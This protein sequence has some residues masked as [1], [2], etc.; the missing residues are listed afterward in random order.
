MSGG[1][2]TWT[3]PD[4]MKRNTNVSCRRLA[5]AVVRPLTSDTKLVKKHGDLH[6]F[7]VYLAY[8]AREVRVGPLVL[9]AESELDM[10]KWMLAFR[11]AS[12]W[13]YHPPCLY[14]LP[15]RLCGL[16]V[17]EIISVEN[18]LV[19][20]WGGKSD[21]YVMVEFDGLLARTETHYDSLTSEF[22]TVVTLP[23][24]NDDPN[25][26]LNFSIFDE[27]SLSHDDLL[28]GVSVPLHSLGFNQ[29]I[30]WDS[31]SVKNVPGSIA[32]KSI[33]SD[34]FGSISFRTLYRSSHLTQFLPLNQI[35]SLVD[36]T[37]GSAPDRIIP[38]S[39]SR[40]GSTLVRRGTSTFAGNSFGRRQSMAVLDSEES[41]E[42]EK[43]P[44]KKTTVVEKKPALSPA[45]PDSSPPATPTG[46]RPVGLPEEDGSYEFSIE[47]F[48]KQL[49]RIVAILKVLKFFKSAS[50]LIAWRDPSWTILI[51]VWVSW[52][53]LVEPQSALMFWY[54]M[55]GKMLLQGH[56]CF[57]DLE[58]E[59]KDWWG[60]M[61]LDRLSLKRGTP[62]SSVGSPLNRN[63]GTSGS[64]DALHEY[65]V[66][67]CQ[68]RR[69]AGAMTMLTTMV[70]VTATM[71]A[72]MAVAAGNAVA[73]PLMT[74]EDGLEHSTATEAV[75]EAKK[76][77]E[78]LFINFSNKNLKPD[79]EASW[80]TLAGVPLAESPATVI[81]GVKVK[82]NVVISKKISDKNG[83]EYAKAFPA[84]AAGTTNPT[85]KFDQHNSVW[86]AGGFEPKLK[87]HRHW[88]RRR[89]WIGIPIRAAF[90][91]EEPIKLSQIVES[92]VDKDGEELVEEGKKH[93]S[94]Y[95]KF[96][97]IMVE[98]RKLQ[99]VL[100]TVVSGLECAKN[101]VTWKSRWISSLVFWMIMAVLLFSLVIPQ[102]VL[103]WLFFSLMLLDSFSDV[104]KKANLT[105]PLLEA[106][107]KE[108]AASSVPAQ[109]KAILASKLRSHYTRMD[110]VHSEVSVSIICSL[111]QK[112]C[113]KVWFPNAV[114]L[115]LED[116]AVTEVSEG[117]PATVAML[118]ERIYL[119]A[120]HGDSDWWKSEK[121][122]IHPK[123][124][125]KGHLVSD[126]EEYDPV[127]VF[128]K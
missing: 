97:L 50:Y 12:G 10:N 48:R 39:F 89:V 11:Q 90:E 79:I 52:V 3:K 34:Q 19:A 106:I 64:S 117:G 120:N 60:R 42:D 87:I 8:D 82:W 102:F 74:S 5:G 37:D 85:I 88:V 58:A 53:C 91:S 68:R 108:V 23:V 33:G 77:L 20:D 2:V 84:L 96:K 25:Q 116:F 66:F 59:V 22:H 101:L 29:E 112:A 110:E 86:G 46:P 103:V 127:S 122:A 113:D 111:V 28:G 49:L 78:N 54:A 47:M 14:P 6:I 9:A 30:V 40:V 92:T 105:R 94:L 17:V 93:L 18:I 100:F 36:D 71:P 62:A 115:T 51:Y 1:C 123:N 81:D 114:V 109:W 76:D 4:D 128:S 41:S 104:K 43:T 126:W 27:D 56:P 45:S 32:G 38:S 75:H 55:V 125:I 98:G 7:L 107:Q 69:I 80:V 67:E 118:L 63:S 99:N 21:P 119:Q 44:K 70:K 57:P 83:W 26:T 124:L 73:A 15:H 35:P 72:Q 95:A 13:L 24:F 61:V 121:V 65:R 31:V 16:I